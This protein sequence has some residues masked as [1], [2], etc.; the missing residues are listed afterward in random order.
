MMLFLAA[1]LLKAGAIAEAEPE[2]SATIQL[3]DEVDRLRQ[4][5]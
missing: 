5:R 2:R 1:A 4:R 3:A